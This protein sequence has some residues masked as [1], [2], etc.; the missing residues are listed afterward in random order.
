MNALHSGLAILGYNV[1]DL[2]VENW[3]FGDGTNEAVLTF[4]SGAK[5]PETG[6]GIAALLCWRGGLKPLYD[7]CRCH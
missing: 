2:E 6:A 3:L 7:Y 5:L 4:Q 1:D